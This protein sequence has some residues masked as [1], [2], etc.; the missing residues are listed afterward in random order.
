MSFSGQD[1]NIV[2]YGVDKNGVIDY[3]DIEDKLYKHNPR[4]LLV[5]ASSY[6]R[7]IDYARIRHILDVYNGGILVELEKEYAGDTLDRAYEES[8]CYYV[9]DMAHVAGLVAGGV[10]PN[11]CRW[12]DVVTSTT[13]KT[14]RGPRGGIILWNDGCFTKR[15]NSAV[16]PRNTRRS[17]RAYYS[18]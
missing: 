1:Y 16:F 4:M 7:I 13:H 17:I 18:R 14:L 5:G 10:H 2:S 11:P 15:I 9:V 3:Q 6:S 8:K 12:A